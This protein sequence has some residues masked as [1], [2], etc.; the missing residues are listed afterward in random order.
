MKLATSGMILGKFLP[1][2][3]G[4][5]HLVE[6]GLSRVERLTVVVGTLS[7]EPIDGK[8]RYQWMRELFPTARVVH[9]DKDLPQEPSEHPDFWNLWI[10]ALREVLPEAPE[11]V[12]SSEDYGD[13]LAQRLGARHIPVDK[14]RSAIPISGT[15]IRQNPYQHWQM[16][17]SCVRTHF[18]KRVVL[19]GTESTGKTTLAAQLAQHFQ[20][21]WAPEFAREFI[22]QQPQDWGLSAIKETDFAQIASGQ[23]RIEDEAARR[24]NRVLFC[25]TN[26]LSSTVWAERYLGQCPQWLRR[27]SAQRRYD[28]YLWAELADTEWHQDRTR[29]SEQ[30]Q[31]QLHQKFGAVLE[32]ENFVKLS[33][34]LETRLSQAIKAVEA[35]F[36]TG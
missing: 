8:L 22:E 9:L 23:Q 13:E 6:F 16:L 36:S 24:A 32:G 33:G 14:P 34:P 1:P 18:V 26:L 5:I 30:M 4:H 2:H 31:T 15:A 10:R 35:L 27:M 25:D 11:L 29:D 12:F 7:T 28:L 17:P 3:R 20:T 19:F 21:E